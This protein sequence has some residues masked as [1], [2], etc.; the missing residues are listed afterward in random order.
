MRLWNPRILRE[1][2]DEGGQRVHCLTEQAFAD[3]GLSQTEGGAGV[4]VGWNRFALCKDGFVGED[5]GFVVAV[6]QGT[7]SGA[8]GNV[9]RDCQRGDGRFGGHDGWLTDEY[10]RGG[11]RRAFRIDDQILRF[12][13]E[14]ASGEQQ[15]GQEKSC[16][17]RYKT[18][19]FPMIH[20][21]DYGE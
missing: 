13:V 11:N 15:Q 2:G 1:A 20:A 21:R 16:P 18:A 7:F 10:V 3:G 12:G 19:H 14:V 17:F 6:E 5:G 4:D 8:Q 9:W